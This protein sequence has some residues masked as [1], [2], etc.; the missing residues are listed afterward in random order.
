MTFNTVTKQFST[1]K[2]F[3][4]TSFSLNKPLIKAVFKNIFVLKYM[5]LLVRCFSKCVIDKRYQYLIND[6]NLS[7]N[8]VKFGIWNLFSEND[9]AG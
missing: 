2:V 1:E 6:K 7:E 9:T 8:T 5:E 3:N 4:Q